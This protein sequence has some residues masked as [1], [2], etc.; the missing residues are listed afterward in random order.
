[1]VTEQRK[2][3]RIREGREKMLIEKMRKRRER[4]KQEKIE[5]REDH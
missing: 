2:K 1:M 4:G 3:R 5:E